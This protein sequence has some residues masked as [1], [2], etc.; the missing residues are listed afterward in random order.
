[1]DALSW[2]FW[3]IP[4]IQDWN[5]PPEIHFTDLLADIS[6]NLKFMGTEDQEK[7]T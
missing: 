1:M 7:S 2:T 6:G 5:R 4:G 3:T